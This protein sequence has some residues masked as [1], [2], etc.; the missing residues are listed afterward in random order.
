MR[1]VIFKSGLSGFI[2]VEFVRSS[3]VREGELL[4]LGFFFG[5]VVFR[6]GF[7]VVD[8]DVLGFWISIGL[9]V[10]PFY[11]VSDFSGWYIFPSVWL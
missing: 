11:Q 2:Y 5:R 6:S 9:F 4:K 7:T 3:L 10:L 8:L 1:V